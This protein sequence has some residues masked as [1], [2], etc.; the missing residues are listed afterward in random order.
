MSW[1]E[2]TI[3]AVVIWAITFTAAV[4]EKPKNNPVWGQEPGIGMSQG[5]SRGGG[6]QLSSRGGVR[7]SL[8]SLEGYLKAPAP[9]LSWEALVRQE[10]QEVKRVME[11]HPNEFTPQDF[12]DLD[13][14]FPI[15]YAAAKEYHVPWYLLWIIH[16]AESTMSQDERAFDGRSYPFFGAVQRHRG[17]HSDREVEVALENAPAFIFEI[18]TRDKKDAEELWWLAWHARNVIN[19]SKLEGDTAIWAVLSA[20]SDLR[21]AS[22]RFSKFLH[23]KP[24]FEK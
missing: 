14:Y 22:P 24:Y 8:G 7:P 20:Y 5:F 1:K 21:Y 19:E 4:V 18:K 15:Y 12:T 2:R 17:F 3:E 10:Y 13:I 16:Q 9:D 6:P 11:A 23:D